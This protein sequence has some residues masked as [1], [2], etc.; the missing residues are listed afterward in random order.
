MSSEMLWK[1]R[2]QLVYAIYDAYDDSDDC[3]V[4]TSDFGGLCYLAANEDLHEWPGDTQYW[5]LRYAT[6]IW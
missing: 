3:T 2:S 6:V 4:M 1:A 5:H